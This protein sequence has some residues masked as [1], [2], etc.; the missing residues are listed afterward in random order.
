MKSDM[1]L[2]VMQLAAERDLPQEAVVSAFEEAV[3]AAYRKESEAQGYDVLAKLD[4]ETGEVTINTIL[5]VVDYIEDDDYAK[6]G[7]I[8]LD[9]AKEIK[10]EAELGDIIVTG[11]LEFKPQR[12]AARTVTQ[13]LMQRLRNAERHLV[14]E[15][16]A[17]KEG[18]I[19][20]ASIRRV[21]LSRSEQAQG[22]RPKV[23]V[24]LGKAD[25]YLPPDEQCTNERYRT[26]M[27]LRFFV[28]QVSH[29]GYESDGAPE[30]V[31]S[32]THPN[33]LRRLLESEVPEV[34]TGIVEIKSIAR[35]PGSRSKAAVYSNK[36]DIDPIGA[37]VG[38]RGIRIQNIVT[39]LMGE[40]IDI[41][42]WSEN[43]AVFISN[44]LGP[45]QVENVIM[46]ADGSA[47]VIVPD[48]QLSLA[49]GREGQNVTLATK[50]TGCNIDIKGAS[51]YAEEQLALQREIEA[52]AAA[53]AEAKAEAERKRLEE[54]EA[55]RIAA[56][57]ADAIEG[58]TDDEVIDGVAVPVADTVSEQTDSVG[59]VEIVEA[60]Q[61]DSATHE[62]AP[63]I[64]VPDAPV[65]PSDEPD[66]ADDEFDE[67]ETEPELEEESEEEE[68]LDLELL[69]LEEKIRELELEE[70]ERKEAERQAAELEALEQ[71]I[72]SD[73]LWTLPSDLGSGQDTQDTGVI[74]AEDIPGYGD[75]D[76]SGRSSRRG[77]NNTGGQRRSSR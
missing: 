22:Q 69:E 61:E 77:G 5:H 55:A 30:I 54:E 53:E 60:D 71:D 45:A 66:L 10:R 8:I 62:T 11:E 63:T 72:D 18:D 68:D 1:L 28:L 14:F 67:V 74:F 12:I 57:A 17:D 25:A 70:A 27:E 59:S 32:R 21:E 41:L 56:Q 24:D 35:D 37:C 49:I 2:A 44:A 42:E 64:F 43:P 51:K 34:K 76:Q 31:L 26:G 48:S 50:L 4:P 40:K 52:A 75:P 38:L 7:Q 29:N 6:K 36:Q 65:K 16:F 23:I 46:L 13:V 3:A 73:E 19:I 15:Q 39:E 58:A 33:L 9:D 47:E 20:S